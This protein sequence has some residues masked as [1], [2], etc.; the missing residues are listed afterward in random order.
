M[1]W[2]VVSNYA[3]TMQNHADHL[4]D[5]QTVLLH[6]CRCSNGRYYDGW[7]NNQ[8]ISVLVTADNN[9]Q[10]SIN[11]ILTRKGCFF[12]NWFPFLEVF[13]TTR[14]TGENPPM[15]DSAVLDVIC[16]SNRVT[17][18]KSFPVKVT[19]LFL[20]CASL[21]S[22][23]LGNLVPASER[24]VWLQ[25]AWNHPTSENKSA[26]EVLLW[27]CV[28][29]CPNELSTSWLWLTH[30]VSAYI[31]GVLM[32]VWRVLHDMLDYI[33]TRLVLGDNFISVD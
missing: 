27:R 33:C 16:H 23:P 4:H 20:I 7:R 28:D 25:R 18:L 2:N 21:C 1:L 11:Q 15:Q 12:L 26:V 24:D 6:V 22:C 5:L 19:L 31:D 13:L 29:V 8:F 17:P 14:W 10:I 30:N 3:V 32:N 9:E